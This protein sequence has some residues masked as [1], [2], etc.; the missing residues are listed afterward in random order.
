VGSTYDSLSKRWWGHKDM[1][2]RKPNYKLYQAFTALGIENFYIERHHG[3]KCNTVEELRAEEGKTIRELDS[4]KNGYN[5]LIAGRKYKE[6]NDDNKEEIKEK[7]KEYREINKQKMEIYN[8]KY[9][10]DNKKELAEKNKEPI[11]CK[12]CNNSPSKRYISKH[13]KSVKHINNYKR[14]IAMEQCSYNQQE[15]LK[16]DVN[17]E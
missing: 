16:N 15:M 8:K 2:K 5:K 10:N 9:Y 17:I 13:N 1:S 3:F 7:Q 6:W 12:Y 14:Y 11:L 4:V